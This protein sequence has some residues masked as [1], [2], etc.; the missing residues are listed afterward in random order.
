MVVVDQAETGGR[1]VVETQKEADHDVMVAEPSAFQTSQ[2]DQLL[3]LEEAVV[4]SAAFVIASAGLEVLFPSSEV[5]PALALQ[6][7]S[8]SCFRGPSYFPIP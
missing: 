5:G 6:A 2:D 1:V 7:L 8:L 3:P 4:C